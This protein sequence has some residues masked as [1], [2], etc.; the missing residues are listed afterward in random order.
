M[1]SLKDNASFSGKK[2]AHFLLWCFVE[3]ISQN[4]FIKSYKSNQY[5]SGRGS[6]LTFKYNIVKIGAVLLVEIDD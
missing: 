2:L 1:R 4:F 5:D 3:L 6:E